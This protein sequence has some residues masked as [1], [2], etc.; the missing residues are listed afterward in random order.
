MQSVERTL[1]VQL[2]EKNWKTEATIK[3]IHFVLQC[4]LIRMNKQNYISMPDLEPMVMRTPAR[5]QNW[6]HFGITKFTRSTGQT[7]EKCRQI[8][9]SQN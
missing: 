7:L 6:C 1:K 3:E 4:L 8:F 9:Q 5:T 2:G